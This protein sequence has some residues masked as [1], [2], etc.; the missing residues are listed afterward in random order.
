MPSKPVELFRSA[1]KAPDDYAGIPSPTPTGE[2]S[3]I[4][5]SRGHKACNS[6]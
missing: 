4:G 2:N 5:G 3:L 6:Q 1:P